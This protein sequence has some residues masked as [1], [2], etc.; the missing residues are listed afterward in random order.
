MIR[1]KQQWS[2]DTCVNEVIPLKSQP[3][4][5]TGQ[6]L[7]AI[8]IAVLDILIDTTGKT[9]SVPCYVL[10]S[11]QPLWLGKL[12]DCGVLMGTNTLVK[13]GFTVTHSNGKQVEQNTKDIKD[14]NGD[15]NLNTTDAGASEQAL[16]SA[17][18]LVF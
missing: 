5:A 17:V 8:G 13:H 7:G 6:T 15:T 10:D 3:I 18:V 2:K 14:P 1:E 16:R 9:C 12:E 11:S 4:G